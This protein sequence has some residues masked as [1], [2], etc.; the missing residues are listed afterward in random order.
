M[1]ML[2]DLGN[3]EQ[4]EVK[5]GVFEPRRQKRIRIDRAIKTRRGNARLTVLCTVMVYDRAKP[6]KPRKASSR[7]RANFE[8]M[9]VQLAGMVN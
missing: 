8:A 7:N 4:Y 6:W 2:L 3:I 1:K 9:A 5:Q